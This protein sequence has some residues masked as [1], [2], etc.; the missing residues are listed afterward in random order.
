MKQKLSKIKPVKTVGQIR[1]KGAKV[2]EPVKI[3]SV[4]KPIEKLLTDS[5]LKMMNSM[6]KMEQVALLK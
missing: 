2:K 3:P 5:Y 6:V 4:V 1:Q